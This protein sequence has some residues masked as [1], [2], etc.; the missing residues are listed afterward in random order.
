MVK[1]IMNEIISLASKAETSAEVYEIVDRKIND[2]MMYCD[3]NPALWSVTSRWTAYGTWR[4][5]LTLNNYAFG[6]RMSTHD[7]S[8]ITHDEDKVKS[9]SED[10]EPEPFD[11]HDFR[12]EIEHYLCDMALCVFEGEEVTI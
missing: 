2:F 9:S 8:I 7:F 5:T 12:R 6:N 3:D 4:V 1:T 11:V 10:G